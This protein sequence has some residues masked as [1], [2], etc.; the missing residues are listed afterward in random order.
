MTRL[1]EPM[2]KQTASHHVPRSVRAA[3]TR[4]F[5]LIEL[6]IVVAIIGILVAVALPSY[7]QY[8][9]RGQIV[10]ATTALATFRG[11]MERYFQDNRTYAAVGAITPPCATTDA[12]LRKVGSFVVTCT[13]TL[14][15]LNFTLAATGSGSTAGFVYTVNQRDQR[16]TTSVGTGSGWNTSTTCWVLKKG[17]S[18]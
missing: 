16:A 8:L 11:N 2:Q 17:D 14:D 15:A 18:C 6:M 5:T 10:D 12:T 4:G 1:I 13:G 7:R 9:L 3:A